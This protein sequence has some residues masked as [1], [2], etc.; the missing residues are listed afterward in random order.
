MTACLAQRLYQCADLLVFP[1]VYDNAPLV[2]K[3]AA[4]MLTP[5]S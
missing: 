5:P 3:E 1:S 2:V 4:V